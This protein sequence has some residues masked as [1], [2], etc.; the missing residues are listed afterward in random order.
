[1]ITGNY[2]DTQRIDFVA[3]ENEYEVQMECPGMDKADFKVTI[4]KGVLTISGEKK[5][6][7]SW[8]DEGTNYYRREIYRGT[9][10]RSL[11]LV[12]QYPVLVIVPWLN[13]IN[14]LD[15]SIVFHSY[16]PQDAG[17]QVK[18]AYQDGVMHITVPK[19]K[20]LQ[21]VKHIGID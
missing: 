10:A 12:C 11:Q 2:C 21:S 9:F 20:E 14:I 6:E 7:A 8:G 17:D 18:A 3:K 4:D 5:Q 13:K 15:F 19:N 1:M 16:Q